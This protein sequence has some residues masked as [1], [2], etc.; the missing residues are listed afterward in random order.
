MYMQDDISSLEW[1]LYEQH[2]KYRR[3]A[4]WKWNVTR[5]QFSPD[6]ILA[7]YEFHFEEQG[8]DGPAKDQ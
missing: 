3:V 1:E 7:T 2:D 6:P 5:F 8:N 4:A